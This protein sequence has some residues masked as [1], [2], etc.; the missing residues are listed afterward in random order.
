[1]RESI[2]EG[3]GAL[4]SSFLRESAQ[5]NAGEPKQ[6][7]L[8]SR[9]CRAL[10]QDDNAARA[11]KERN[12]KIGVR[13]AASRFVSRPSRRENTPS[14]TARVTSARTAEAVRRHAGSQAV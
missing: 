3:R 14:A 2:W 8:R 11:G 4:P 7:V 9:A 6:Q 12:G 13:I 1:M 10:A 5:S